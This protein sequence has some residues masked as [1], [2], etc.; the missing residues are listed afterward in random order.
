MEQEIIKTTWKCSSFTSD[1]RKRI[2]TDAGGPENKTEV[3]CSFQSYS[4]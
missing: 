1:C 2:L 4:N 3:V